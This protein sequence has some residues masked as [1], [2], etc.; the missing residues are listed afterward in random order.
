M[1]GGAVGRRAIVSVAVHAVAHLQCSYLFDLFHRT[2]IPVAGRTY[3]SFRDP[4][5][6]AENAYVRLMHKMNMVG[7]PMHSHPSHWLSIVEGVSQFLYLGLPLF[8]GSEYRLV[9]GH[10]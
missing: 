8:I 10:T 7:N 3:G 1:A 6:R 4:V 5:P 2:D 9:A